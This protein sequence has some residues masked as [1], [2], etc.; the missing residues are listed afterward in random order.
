MERG[1]QHSGHTAPILRG[2]WER[3]T[4]LGAPRLWSHAWAACCLFLGLLLLTY[5]GFRWVAL[6]LLLWIIGQGTLVALTAW[7][8]KWDEMILAQGNRKYK[9]RYGA[10]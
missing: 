9:S 8:P 5:W 10:G 7:N 1:P 2:V 6:P 3:I 4:T